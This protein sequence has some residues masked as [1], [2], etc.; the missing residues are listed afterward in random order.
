[1]DDNEHL[2]THMSTQNLSGIPGQMAEPLK[3]PATN[4][5]VHQD[6]IGGGF[7]S[8][9]KSLPGNYTSQLWFV[10]PP[11]IEMQPQFF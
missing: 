2:F 4:M 11:R 9:Q 7:G 10:R 6:N 1:M 8:I 3:F 5:R